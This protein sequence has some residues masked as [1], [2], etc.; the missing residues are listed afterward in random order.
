MWIFFWIS[1]KDVFFFSLAF[2]P[3][4]LVSEY[5]SYPSLIA[6]LLAKLTKDSLQGTN[7]L[8][9]MHLVNY[10]V[11]CNKH[12]HYWRSFR[13]IGMEIIEQITDAEILATY[14]IGKL[15]SSQTSQNDYGP[16]KRIATFITCN[17]RKII[18]S[19]YLREQLCLFCLI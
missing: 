9:S 7:S 13:I 12:S 10:W 3:R 18:S 16:D 17:I 15:V 5:C 19:G 8:V 14:C 6:I 4:Q 2:C 1:E 11:E